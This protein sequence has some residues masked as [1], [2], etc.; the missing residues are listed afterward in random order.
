M[1]LNATLNI[2]SPKTIA[3]A[4][5]INTDTIIGTKGRPNIRSSSIAIIIPFTTAGTNTANT[6]DDTFVSINTVIAV[7]SVPNITSGIPIG[8]KKFAIAV[9]SIIEVVNFLLKNGNNTS[10]SLNLKLIPV[11]P[12]LTGAVTSV[13]T[14]YNAATIADNV[15]YLVSIFFNIRHLIPLA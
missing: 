15:R 11:F 1:F 3:A 10:I 7:A 5:P 4:S 6:F 8:E 9:P 14:T 13:N 2:T 12:K